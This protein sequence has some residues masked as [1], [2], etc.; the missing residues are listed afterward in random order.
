MTAVRHDF[1]ER[2]CDGLPDP[3]FTPS[4]EP[5]ID[6]VPT[7]V[8]GRHVAPRSTAPKPPEDAVDDRAVLLGRPASTTV[9]GLDGQ[10]TLQNAPFRFGEIAPA[11]ACLQKEALN[12]PYGTTSITLSP[13]ALIC[14]KTRRCRDKSPPPAQSFARSRGNGSDKVKGHRAD[15]HP[16][17]R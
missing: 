1:G 7:A 8:F 13:A 15:R 3:G 4:P 5:T 16:T 12:Q 2:H 14:P 10:Q 17:D 9:R 11:Q 6:A